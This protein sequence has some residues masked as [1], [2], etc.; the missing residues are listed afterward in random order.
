M[1]IP[2]IL[3]GIGLLV[4]GLLLLAYYVAYLAF[5]LLQATASSRFA[6]Y[7]N[8]MLCIVI[9]LT[10]VDLICSILHA[11][12]GDAG[13]AKKGKVSNLR[14]IRGVSFQLAAYTA[15]ASWKLTPRKFPESRG[16]ARRAA[17]CP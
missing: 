11:L 12:G 6:T 2:M 16:E 14:E 3:A 13:M 17:P 5:L 4:A 15:I 9:P 10:F 8:A 1:T 7:A